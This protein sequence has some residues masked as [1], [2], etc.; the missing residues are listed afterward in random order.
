MGVVRADEG[1]A[2]FGHFLIGA[3]DML[4]ERMLH[5]SILHVVGDV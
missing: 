5:A 4:S 2:G 1:D 3:A